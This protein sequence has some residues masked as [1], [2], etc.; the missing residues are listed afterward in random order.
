MNQFPGA[1]IRQRT[2][3]HK[4]G[5]EKLVME[6]NQHADIIKQ[7]ILDMILDKN[8]MEIYGKT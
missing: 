3:M 2:N 1:K 7:S 6:N 4:P 8:T 5:K